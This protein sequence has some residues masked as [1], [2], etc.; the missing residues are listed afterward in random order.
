MNSNS[1]KQ[2]WPTMEVSDYHLIFDLNGVLVVI[3]E[4]QIKSHSIVLRPNLK[5]FLSTCVNKFMV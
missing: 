4:N 2:T 3:G 5:E 1:Y